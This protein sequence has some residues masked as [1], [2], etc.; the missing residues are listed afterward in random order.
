M[1]LKL[2]VA[3]GL[4]WIL[5]IISWM[6]IST[7]SNVPEWFT[8]VL[9]IANILQGFVVFVIFGLKATIRKI[10]KAKFI[11]LTASSNVRNSEVDVP[12]NNLRISYNPNG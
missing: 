5:E 4:T 2:F 7:K 6:I 10:F 12:L 9:N 3:L 8:G 1:F 11:E